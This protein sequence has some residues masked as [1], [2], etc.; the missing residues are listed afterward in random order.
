MKPETTHPEQFA[1]FYTDTNLGFDLKVIRK[2]FDIFKPFF[3]QGKALELG[4]GNGTMTQL[5]AKYF[6]ELTVVEGA[7]TLLNQIP[8]QANLEKVHSLFDDYNPGKC[9][10]TIIMNHVLEHIEYP[11]PLL[12]KIR[13]WLADDG[14]FILGVPNAKSFHRLAA[15]KMGLLQSEYALNERDHALGHYRVYDLPS[16]KQDA[17]QA[18]FKIADEGGIFLK[19]LSNKQIEERLDDA[20]VNAYFEIAPDFYENAAEIFLILHK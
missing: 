10:D 16:L 2:S 7:A 3:K 18:G 13:N 19:F 20:I 12:E 1:S 5:L 9:F 15:V 6:N 14:V 11:L 17:L 4:P 8:E